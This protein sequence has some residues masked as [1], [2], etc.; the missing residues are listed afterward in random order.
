MNIF[1][2]YEMKKNAEK[3]SM[4]TCYDYTSARILAKTSVN[5]LL[6]G[7]SVAMTMHGYKDTLSA[8]L[9]MMCFHTKA[10]SRGAENKFILG[11]LPFLSY[12]K[13]LSKNVSAAQAL[14]QAGANAVKLECASG[15]LEL[16]K[17]LT[18]SG[19]PVMGHIGLTPQCIHVLGGY[20]VQGKSHESAAQLKEDACRLQ[21]AGCFGLVLECIPALLAQDITQLLSIPT[22]GIGAG[23]YTDGQ[24]LVFQ[25]L[26][27][28]NMDF[29][30]KF[31]KR[32]LDGDE[33]FIKG[34]ESYIAE[35]KN[36]N[37]PENEHC[38]EE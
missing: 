28:L 14:M 2:F 37:F 6:V 27:G 31:V 24:V 34:I 23:P 17:H 29:K 4:V 33:Q 19:I 36:G 26:L 35:I 9:D 21:E 7:D 8:T 12:R 38:Y 25:D 13:S 18:E 20:K 10:V 22:I 5:C 32:F 1:N 3:I 30:P 11:D 16:I 15:N